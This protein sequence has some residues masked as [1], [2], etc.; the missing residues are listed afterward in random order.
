MDKEQIDI[1]KREL[2]NC[3]MKITKNLVIQG[4]EKQLKDTKMTSKKKFRNFS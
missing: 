2:S 1:L 4:S 3:W